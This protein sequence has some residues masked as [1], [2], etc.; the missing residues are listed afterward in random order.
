MT[1]TRYGRVNR[2]VALRLYE[3]QRQCSVQRC[4]LHVNLEYGFIAASPDGLIG[5]DGIVK[6]KCPLS[7]KEY[8]ACL[9]RLFL[10]PRL[11]A[12]SSCN[13]TNLPKRQ[14]LSGYSPSRSCTSLLAFKAA[15]EQVSLRDKITTTKFK[16]SCT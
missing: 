14:P 15:G 5:T 13:C 16:E 6:V 10:C 7:K 3:D 12:F 4:G 8:S 11:C 1:A 2:I 9:C